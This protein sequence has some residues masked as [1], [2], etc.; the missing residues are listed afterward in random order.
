MV[1][2]VEVTERVVRCGVVEVMFAESAEEAEQWVIDR[3]E[4]ILWGDGERLGTLEVVAVPYREVD[5]NGG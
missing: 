4:E 2:K 5:G 3:E 1:F